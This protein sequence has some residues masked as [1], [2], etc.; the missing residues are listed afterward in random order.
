MQSVE[1]S[2]KR[3]RSL[4]GLENKKFLIVNLRFHGDVLLTKPMIDDLKT[5][6]PNALIDLLVFKGTASLLKDDEFINEIIE[7]ET[8][9]ELNFW[10]R[11]SSEFS[12][13][14][15]LRRS[16]Y[17]FGFFLTTQW[18][19]ALISISMI[20][21][22]TGAV[23]DKKREGFLWVN[24][25][26]KTFPEAGDN[27]IVTRNLSALNIFDMCISKNPSL[28]LSIS[29][30]TEIKAA[31]I[32][33]SKDLSTKFCVI[34]PISRREVKMWKKENFIEL[35][36]LLESKGFKVV[37]SSGPDASEVNYVNLLEDNANLRPI[38][39]GGQTS[40]IELAA[41][42]KKA[43][44]FIGL[45][46]VASHI[47]AAVNTPSITLFGP[48]NAINWR[49]W[50]KKSK[51]ICREGD[52]KFCEDHG[53]REGKFKKCLCYIT[54]QRVIEE[55]DNLYFNQQDQ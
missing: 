8:S 36:D 31:D 17:D 5:N 4:M 28:D 29:K 46:S 12:L 35:I 7:I 47:A 14:R 9:K 25:F 11:I 13:I 40:L 3:V 24:S 50:S 10:E 23:S 26:T 16:N 37:L 44:F 30:K 48:T 54:P 51:I 20:G 53:H 43:D 32:L 18:R 38:N 34:H 39:I 41:I 21:T 42:I 6:Y 52:E 45:D 33:K 19:L 1:L 22:K 49:P 15:S 55:L 27:H 2:V